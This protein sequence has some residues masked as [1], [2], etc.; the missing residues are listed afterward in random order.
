MTSKQKHI[1]RIDFCS[2]MLLESLLLDSDIERP[3]EFPSK[4]S[5][6]CSVPRI[7]KL[8]TFFQLL[9]NRRARVLGRSESNDNFRATPS[10]ESGI[11]RKNVNKKSY[12][13]FDEI[14]NSYRSL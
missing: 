1:H 6:A 10:D 7:L 13:H 11:S 3:D 4:T 2:P 8:T 12:L 5:D 9:N 14:S